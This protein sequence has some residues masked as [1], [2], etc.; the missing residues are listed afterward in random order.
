MLA[1]AFRWILGCELV[2]VILPLKKTRSKR[3][4]FSWEITTVLPSSG[5]LFLPG[6][7]G[8]QPSLRHPPHPAAG[9]GSPWSAPHRTFCLPAVGAGGVTRELFS[10]HKQDLKAQSWLLGE[11]V[12]EVNWCCALNQICKSS[13]HASCSCQHSVGLRVSTSPTEVSARSDGQ[14]QQR[15]HWTLQICNSNAWNN[16]LSENTW[17]FACVRKSKAAQ[18]I[19]VYACISRK[20]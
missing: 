4:H 13:T 10:R 14:S 5:H 2:E 16:I 15:V 1:K 20:F 6:G 8:G 7:R 3:L 11:F 12:S 9:P 19:F 18:L 17:A